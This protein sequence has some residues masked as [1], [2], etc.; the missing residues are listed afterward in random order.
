MLLTPDNPKAA[1]KSNPPN[2]DPVSKATLPPCVS[3]GELYCYGMH[4]KYPLPTLPVIGHS[5]VFLI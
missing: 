4:Q 5:E 2:L 3:Y 1:A